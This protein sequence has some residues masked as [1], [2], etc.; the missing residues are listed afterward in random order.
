MKVGGKGNIVK[1]GIWS[2]EDDIAFEDRSAVI[3]H[4]A[5]DCWKHHPKCRERRRYLYPPTRLIDVGKQGE[6]QWPNLI[7]TKSLSVHER[8]ML[9]YTTL[10]HRWGKH[11][12]QP[13]MT[14]KETEHAHIDGISPDEIPSTFR[15][16]ILIT[17]R[18]GIRFIWIDSLCIIQDDP[19]DWQAEAARMSDVYRGSHLNIAAMDAED[20]HGGC[21]LDS[22]EPPLQIRG[23]T[24]G[25]EIRI[26]IPPAD[27]GSVSQSL[28][29]ERGWIFQELVLANRILYC[30]KE[31]FYWQCRGRSTSEDGYI[32]HSRGLNFQCLSTA[33]SSFFESQRTSPLMK[34]W[35][36][37]ASDYV[38]RDFTVD[39]DR[40][41]ALAGITELQ[42]EEMVSTPI[43][44]LWKET[45]IS[46]LMWR[47]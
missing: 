30:S 46:D 3:R 8:K 23:S 42:Q 24:E 18:L 4:W 15:D 9:V 39:E 40:L 21:H 28:L 13:L 34:R 26:R 29:N 5:D 32:D 10:S 35:W 17:R 27:V 6:S 47:V 44:G 45:F 1:R 36:Q 19:A 38:K 20:C 14:T 12:S 11:Q 16:A 22:I 43:L 33:R 2:A 37:W 41:A 31:Q 7:H 25:P